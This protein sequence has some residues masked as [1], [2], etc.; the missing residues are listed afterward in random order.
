M[1]FGG[2]GTGV[3]AVR[4]S[5]LGLQLGRQ[6]S[7]QQVV[8]AAASLGNRA[9]ATWENRPHP[10]SV[11]PA[12]ASGP[13]QQEP[14]ILLRTL[15]QDVRRAAAPVL[16]RVRDRALP[17]SCLL[18]GDAELARIRARLMQRDEPAAALVAA[19]RRPADDSDRV[20]MAD[21]HDALEH[22][23]PDDASPALRALLAAM[24]LPAA[25]RGEVADALARA[26]LAE[27][28][29][30]AR[31]E[32]R[33]PIVFI[34]LVDDAVREIVTGAAAHLKPGGWLLAEVA[35]NGPGAAPPAIDP[36]AA[37]LDPAA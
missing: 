4:G 20:A 33:K 21:F 22:G 37:P 23:A 11:A 12:R 10:A 8:T 36:G 32:G 19:M 2:S 35:W 14:R 25:T 17:Q 26:V 5:G 16:A 1:G 27:I 34:T 31:S 13:N 6:R 7:F 24:G 9:R 28:N 18:C 30:V 3:R 29:E 15:Y